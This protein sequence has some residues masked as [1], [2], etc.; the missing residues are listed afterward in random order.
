[1]SNDV[2]VD[3]DLEGQSNK[4]QE[5]L[6][7]MQKEKKVNEARE[8][9][10]EHRRANEAGTGTPSGKMTEEQRKKYEGKAP[11]GENMTPEEKAAY[12]EGYSEG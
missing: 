3:S 9:G 12:K 7:R 1:M 5:N 8:Q 2:E 4:I 6:R 10:R 11:A